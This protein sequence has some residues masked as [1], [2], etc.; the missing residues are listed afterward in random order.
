MQ[1]KKV[2]TQKAINIIAEG[3]LF[4]G[5]TNHTV[6]NDLAQEGIEYGERYARDLFKLATLQIK[7]HFAKDAEAT[8]ETVRMGIMRLYRE[9][10]CI[11]DRKEQ[12]ILLREL[13][14]LAGLDEQTITHKVDISDD[15]IQD[16][17]KHFM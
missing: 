5:W 3:I 2:K 14:K 12:R 4:S 6:R 8:Y 16:F 15:N 10:M 7:E 11:D 1:E 17:E 9:A 13:A